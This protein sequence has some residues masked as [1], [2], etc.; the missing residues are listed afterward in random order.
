MAEIPENI[1]IE[2]TKVAPKQAIKIFSDQ[3]IKVTTTAKA[4]QEAVEERLFAITRSVNMGVLQDF[5]GELKLAIEEGQT[6]RTFQKNIKNTL[7][8]H[9][10][11]GE[12]TIIQ[13]GKEIEVLTTPHRLKTIYKTNIQSS[14]NAGRF[15]RQIENAND[16]PFLQLIE[17]LDASTRTTH[18]AQ[19]GSIQLISSRFWKSPNSWYPPNGF[20]CRGR[21]TSLTRAEA[22]SR[23]I[24][25]KSPGTKPDPGFGLNPAT[26]FF[27]PNPKD[28]DDDIVAAA[29]ENIKPPKLS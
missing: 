17:I 25:I 11:T 8:K 26:E 9:G 13:A 3:G 12:R 6:F 4:T 22:K 27:K 14:L 15:E 7:A 18:R 5:R 21:T 29:G 20:N 10:W 24:K 28:F 19:S 23:G 1:I 16:R 2:A